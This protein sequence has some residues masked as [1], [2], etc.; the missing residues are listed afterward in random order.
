MSITRVLLSLIL[1]GSVCSALAAAAGERRVQ[2]GGDSCDPVVSRF[3]EGD[4]TVAVDRKCEAGAFMR[5]TCRQGSATVTYASPPGAQRSEISYGGSVQCA[6]VEEVT[7]LGSHASDRLD[8]SEVRR[9]E[10]FPKGR[11]KFVNGLKGSDIILGSQFKDDLIA[12]VGFQ[13]SSSS[14]DD[15][16]VRGFGGNDYATGGPGEDDI[17][18]GGG[19]DKLRGGDKADALHG[20]SG[21]DTLV[22][23]EGDDTLVGGPGRDS[24][25]GGPGQNA[26]VP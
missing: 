2:A 9:S 8:L 25:R 12:G 14:A 11:R 18:G 5:V 10:G 23:Q 4:L 3:F 13:A 22:G 6:V 19:D 1:L 26:L 7:L 17:K 15:D 16:R 24:L 20:N 21:D